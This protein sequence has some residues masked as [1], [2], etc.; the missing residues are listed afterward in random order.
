MRKYSVVRKASAPGTGGTGVTT[1][2]WAGVTVLVAGVP[3]PPPPAQPD[4]Q[5]ATT[6]GP[7][8]VLRVMET[9]FVAKS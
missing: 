4:R 2:G 9:L 6:T 5:S 1:V 7:K 3:P 8:L